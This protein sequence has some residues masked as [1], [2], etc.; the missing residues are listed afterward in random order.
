MK[1]QREY[2]FAP[3]RD[4]EP[5]RLLLV[6][7]SEPAVRLFG[8][9]LEDSGLDAELRHE[10]TL[11]AAIASFE[12]G[13][14]DLILLDLG[15]P[16]SRGLET[17]DRARAALVDVPTVVLTGLDDE[18]VAL[19]SLRRGVEDYLVKDE[20]T[21]RSLARTVR[22]VI[23]RDRY[24]REVREERAFNRA[25]LRS[26]GDHIAVLDA[27]GR[28]V[29]TNPAWTAFARSQGGRP[30]GYLGED[31]LAVTQAAAASDETARRMAWGLERVLRGASDRFE[32]EYPCHS[33][34]EQ[35][36]F[37][38][39][40]TPMVS[41]AGGAV[42][43]HANVTERRLRE[44]ALAASED[45]Y[46]S[47]FQQSLDPIS[48]T[49]RDGRI[50]EVNDA[51]CELTG[52]DRDEIGTLDI[53]S[54]Y[55]DATD[56]TRIYE[57]LDAEG[58]VRDF[59]CRLRRSDGTVRVCRVT[60]TPRHSDDGEVAV[61]QCIFRDVTE[62]KRLE[63]ELQHRALHDPLTDLPNRALLGDRAELA[64]ARSRRDGT[65]MG[66]FMLDLDRFKQLNDGLG[67]TAGDRALVEVGRR[68]TGVFRE[69]DTVA[70]VGGDEFA[71]LVEEVP[72]RSELER[73]LERA[74]R[75]LEE[76]YVLGG[77]ECQLRAS[78]G[79][80]VYG[81][82][83]GPEAPIEGW[84]DLMRYAD[85]A[86]SR[87]KLDPVHRHHFFDPEA[88]LEGAARLRRERELRG[89]IERDEFVLHYQPI[90]RLATGEVVGVEPLARWSHPQRG[91]L[92][93]ETFIPLAEE[94]GLIHQLGE[95]LFRKACAWLGRTDARCTDGSPLV[96]SPNLSG[97]Q[98]EEP[99]L[100]SNIAAVI[101]AEGIRP[102]QLHFEVT[103][104]AIARAMERIAE[105]KAIG[106]RVAVDDFGTGYSS[107]TY[108]RELDVDGIKI[109]M[110]FVHGMTE[111]RR[112]SAI[113]E[114]VITLGQA[115][116]LDTLAEGI[117]T[118]EQRRAVTELGCEYGQGLL[119]S[120]PLPADEI[121]AY[122]EEPAGIAS[123]GRR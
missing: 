8:A 82:G 75:A 32:L 31:Y 40:V 104:T 88:D 44:A 53:E 52:Y 9:L 122:L 23:V 109:D 20:L 113:V 96:M 85:L 51:W 92:G 91:L 56:R 77:E 68:L 83:L 22:Y 93:P 62:R 4:T 87:A 19:E 120:P 27:E 78:A 54:L 65:P 102:D 110:S 1:L 14:Y 13:T 103:E 112:D 94:T 36:W 117:E 84:A 16:G 3:A 100:V 98:F 15:L 73:M 116:G 80:V 61:V 69:G 81:G 90:V 47:L 33:P 7:D 76:P 95:L 105:L 18:S 26:L 118:D 72:S 60:G 101:E 63:E 41:P 48:V 64:M 57:L 17:V 99:E 11:E 24:R 121:C 67:H 71:V 2:A 108:V 30:D 5:F 59:E 119:F 43:S 74:E 29:E 12:A 10:R 114:T 55:V 107:L 79:M 45:R 39:T 50:M 6:E 58:G 111:D 115:L 86:L 38:V 97:R 66:L 106:V 46:R 89:A 37:R 35:R 123:G 34:E 70:R 49:R 21:P 28:I 42:V 25:V